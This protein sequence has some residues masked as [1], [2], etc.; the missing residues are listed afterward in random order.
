MV[1][2]WFQEDAISSG[3]AKLL[4]VFIGLVALSM[5]VQAITVIYL[6]VKGMKAL[7]E[8]SE[9]ATELKLKALPL[10]HTAA[11]VMAKTKTVVEEAS[12]IVREAA[13]KVKSISDNLV[14]MSQ[15]AKMSTQQLER[16][17]SDA[18]MRT[19]RQVARVDGM[20][21]AALTTTAELIETVNNGIRGPAHKIA[22]MTTQA[23][24]AFEALLD[25]VKSRGVPP[26]PPKTTRL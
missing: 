20:I 12:A 13:P 26:S 2:M 25:K 22:V 21:T 7:K 14:D 23:K 24:L 18:N 3:N 9:M 5:V 6:T 10:M 17:V 15:T 11:E 19:Q 16:T 1:A 4:M 8:F